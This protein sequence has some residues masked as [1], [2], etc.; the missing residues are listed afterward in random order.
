LR[1]AAGRRYDES[2]RAEPAN[3]DLPANPDPPAGPDLPASPSVPANPMRRGMSDEVLVETGGGIMTITL[4][5]PRARNAINRAL[6]VGVGAALDEFDARADLT[7]AILTGAGRTFCSG[8]DLRA[9]VRGES[10]MLPKGLAGITG[11]PPAKPVIAAVEGYALAGG[12]EIALACDL[13]TAAD[14]ASFGLPEPKRGLIAGGGG[15]YRLPRRIPY[16]VA[17]QLCLTGGFLSAVDAHRYGLVNTLTS[18]G[19]ALEAAK[20]LA[21]EIAANA[22]KAVERSKAIVTASADWPTDRWVELQAPI[23]EAAIRSKD[24]IEGS[25]AF[26]EKRAPVWTGE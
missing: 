24:A 22:P 5:R 15:L 26:T 4:N 13:I 25:L 11:Q 16:N 14:D 2:A 1:R 19:G 21:T 7:V 12:F 18:P 3:P 17:M 10:P 9:F 6:S 23:F 8:M 20:A